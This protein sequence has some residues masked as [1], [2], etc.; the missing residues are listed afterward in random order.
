MQLTKQTIGIVILVVFLVVAGFIVIKFGN[1]SSSPSDTTQAVAT[2]PTDS[3]TATAAGTSPT[4]GSSS[5][6]KDGTYTAIGSYQSPAGTES[7]DV[8]ITLANDIVTNSN[9]VAEATDGTSKHYQNLFISGYKQYVIGKNISDINL[10]KVSGS[11][12][13]PGGFDQALA[14]IETAAQA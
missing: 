7:I 10:D 8:T 3:E 14:K 1:K 11:S 13:T 5:K 12:L 6:Y 9:V 4:P 2:T